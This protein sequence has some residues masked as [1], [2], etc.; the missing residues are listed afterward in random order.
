MRGSTGN[1]NGSTWQEAGPEGVTTSDGAAVAAS[2]GDVGDGDDGDGDGD[3]PPADSPL[4]PAAISTSSKAINYS[5]ILRI[6]FSFP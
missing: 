5:A 3:A 1:S 6:A 4:H 2:G